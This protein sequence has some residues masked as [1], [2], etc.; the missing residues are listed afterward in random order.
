MT[1][2]ERRLLHAL[3]NMCDQ[4]LTDRRDGLLDHQSMMAGEEAVECLSQYG[5]VEPA[6]R[7]GRWTAAGRAILES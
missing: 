5:L 2:A 1:D 7:G 3:A 4:Y 6:P